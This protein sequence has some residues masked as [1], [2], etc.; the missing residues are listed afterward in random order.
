MIISTPQDVALLDARK[1]AEMFRKVHVPV[2]LYI[3]NTS[4]LFFQNA[5]KIPYTATIGEQSIQEWFQFHKFLF[6]KKKGLE[7]ILYLY[8]ELALAERKEFSQADVKIVLNFF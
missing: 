6:K 3:N 5:K 2:S 1:G 8:Q 7:S 4:R